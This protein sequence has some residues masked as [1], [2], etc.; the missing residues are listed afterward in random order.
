LE[1]RA[2]LL[3]RFGCTSRD[4]M[5][6]LELVQRLLASLAHGVGHVRVRPEAALPLLERARRVGLGEAA[7]LRDVRPV[8]RVAERKA[9]VH[10]PARV[11]AR[12][13]LAGDDAHFLR[14][15]LASVE[16][17]QLTPDRIRRF[18]SRRSLDLA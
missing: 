15:L 6:E 14:A 11:L 4:S 3:Q 12:E 10:P 16:E 7:H 5:L 1:R 17:E 8:A 9:C 18:A 13:E 2:S